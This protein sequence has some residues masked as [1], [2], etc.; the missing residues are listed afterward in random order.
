M[1]NGKLIEVTCL[2]CNKVLY[3]VPSR[4]K[5]FKTCSM[6]CC[7]KFKTVGKTCQICD[8]KFEV[9]PCREKR[10]KYCSNKCQIIGS[11]LSRRAD[12]YLFSCLYCKKEKLITLYLKK[13]KKFCSKSCGSLWWI[14][15]KGNKGNAG[16]RGKE[17]VCWMGGIKEY[18]FDFNNRLKEEIRMI[19]NNE[20]FLCHKTEKE[21]KV[22]LSVHHIDYDKN[23]SEKNN[24]VP[25]C[26]SC[27]GKTSQK[28]KRDDFTHLL[29][30]LMYIDKKL[31]INTNIGGH[32]YV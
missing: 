6:K 30:N 18:S 14:K 19:N 13:S 22:K 7:K 5:T 24:L 1:V 25:L 16:K 23:N 17:S 29:K 12:T 20:C 32:T 4:S 3:V 2:S 21:N 11:G 15:N 10:A 27:H 26:I 8:K 9:Y 28:L 31:K